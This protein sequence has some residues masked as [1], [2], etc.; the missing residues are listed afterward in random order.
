VLRTDSN[1]LDAAALPER[2][3]HTV[4][5]ADVIAQQSAPTARPAEALAPAPE[6]Q[7]PMQLDDV[8]RQTLMR[9][10]EETDGNRQQAASLLGISRSTL[11]RMLQRYQ[12]LNQTIRYWY[13]AGLLEETLPVCFEHSRASG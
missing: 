8:I 7:S 6:S 12:L 9:S 13:S 11:Y 1:C 10:L 3:T 5:N 2:V 4:A